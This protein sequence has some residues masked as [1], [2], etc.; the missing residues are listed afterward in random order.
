MTARCYVCSA[1]VERPADPRN[2]LCEGCAPAREHVVS[3][4]WEA[5]RLVAECR[6]GWLFRSLPGGTASVA[7]QESRDRCVKE[8]WR[9]VIA[10]PAK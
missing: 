9:E 5:S 8:H 2:P 6:C 7:A 10:E 1:E 4:R 3:M